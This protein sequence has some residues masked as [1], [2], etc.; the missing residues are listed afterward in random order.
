MTI[1]LPNGDKFVFCFSIFT[2]IL[3]PNLIA[4]GRNSKM[5]HNNVEHK[6]LTYF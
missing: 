5:V 3:F 2:G 1:Y 6:H 4:L